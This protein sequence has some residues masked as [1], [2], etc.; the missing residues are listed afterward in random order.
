MDKQI[1]KNIKKEARKKRVRA[2]ISGTADCPRLC[3]SRSNK[4]MYVQVIDDTKGVTLAS[5]H[6]K[7]LKTEK[8]TKVDS[9]HEL[10][11]AIAAKALQK[12]VNKVVFDRAGNRYHGRLKALA[13]GAREGG[14]KF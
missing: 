5:V 4:F 9:S 2:V 8:A 3:V 6:T 12:N 13:D 11:K 7:E 10:G 1:A 14:L